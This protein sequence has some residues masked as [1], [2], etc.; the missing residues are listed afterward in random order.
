MI[1]KLIYDFSKIKLSLKNEKY[2]IY[3]KDNKYFL[4]KEEEKNVILLSSE[5][6]FDI[7]DHL[8]SLNPELSFFISDVNDIEEIA[9]SVVSNVRKKISELII[10]KYH[11]RISEISKLL[12]ILSITFIEEFKEDK[13]NVFL[14]NL[15]IFY[16][17]SNKEIEI[18]FNTDTEKIIEEFL[19]LKKEEIKEKKG[20][21]EE[22][23]ESEEIRKEEKVIISDSLIISLKSNLEQY[24]KLLEGFEEIKEEIIIYRDIFSG[25]EIRVKKVYRLENIEILD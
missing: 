14:K 22:N 17:E 23:K 18:I 16:N 8:V 15:K 19:G 4:E 24:K 9:L 11:D 7:I 5:N 20:E 21:I 25:K 13:H 12:S 10:K 2:I 6:I 1:V 3:R